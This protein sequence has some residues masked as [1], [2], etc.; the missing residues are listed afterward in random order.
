MSDTLKPLLSVCLVA[1]GEKIHGRPINIYSLSEDDTQCVE[2]EDKLLIFKLNKENLL[3]KWN[4]R[5][6]DKQG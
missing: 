2:F 4:L 5:I 1:N 3:A 6:A